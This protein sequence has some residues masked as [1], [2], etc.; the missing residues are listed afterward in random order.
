MTSATSSHT[1]SCTRRSCRSCCVGPLRRCGAW[2]TLA[3]HQEGGCHV[4]GGQMDWRF[5]LKKKKK[6]RSAFSG[7]SDR[8]WD[9]VRVSVLAGHDPPIGGPQHESSHPNVNDLLLP[10]RPASVTTQAVD[11][12][13]DVD[14]RSGWTGASCTLM[15]L[16]L[17][18]RIGAGWSKPLESNRR[19]SD[20]VPIGWGLFCRPSLLRF[21]PRFYRLI[22]IPAFN[23][24]LNRCFVHDVDLWRER[25]A[26]H[27]K[28]RWTAT[29]FSKTSHKNCAL[30]CKATEVRQFRF[31]WR[32]SGAT[33]TWIFR[34]NPAT[35]F[36]LSYQAPITA[37]RMTSISALDFLQIPCV[38]CLELYH[39]LSTADLACGIFVAC[40]I[41][42]IS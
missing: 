36:V 6:L 7:T 14:R 25:S 15:L 16:R 28:E 11:H 41:T 1:C 12:R 20:D 9:H 37:S 22:N 10:P 29:F 26:R 17:L 31:S 5:F 27:D 30:K 13:S 32:K 42:I 19:C 33:R 38:S 39:S 8:F 40:G 4:R 34:K 35:F 18:L 23:F 3:R 21:G 2:H 24:L